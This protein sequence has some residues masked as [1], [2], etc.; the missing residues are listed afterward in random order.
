MARVNITLDDDTMQRL[1]RHA[2]HF[3]LASSAAARALIREALERREKLERR[4]KIAKDYAAGREDAAQV[5][6]AMEG[7]QLELLDED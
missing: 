7:A 3:G 4:N 2:K 1:E 5:L 6:R